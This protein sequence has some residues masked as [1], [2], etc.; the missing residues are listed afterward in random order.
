MAKNNTYKIISL[1]F[2]CFPRRILTNWG[3]KP[4]KQEGE[5][6]LPFDL[7]VTP[8]KS[9]CEILNNNF[10][11]YFKNL[12][13]NKTDSI[14]Y[15]SKY[16][17]YYYHDFDCDEKSKLINRFA[18]RIDNFKKVIN[19]DRFT[20]FIHCVSEETTTKEINDLYITLSNLCIIENFKLIILNV[21]NK[22]L[23]LPNYI[24]VINIQH[25]YKNFHAQWW[26]RTFRKSDEGIE[27]ETK[28][29]ENIKS[30]ISQRHDIQLYPEKDYTDDRKEIFV[31][32]ADIPRYMN[33]QLFTKKDN[34]ILNI[35]KK[36]YN[37]IVSDEPDFLF[38]SSFGNNFEKY[39]NCT[40]IFINWEPIIPNYNQCDYSLSYNDI[41]FG[42]RNLRWPNFY[43][44]LETNVLDKSGIDL[45]FAKRKFCNFI[46]I[47]ASGGEGAKLRNEFCINLSK[48]RKVDCPGKVLNNMNPNVI[49]PR[50]GDYT[51]GKLNFMK[52]YK[53]SII[54]ENTLL[55]GYTTEKIV[56]AFLANTIPIY[57]G[58]PDVIKEF[59]PR[60]FINCNDY[61]NL[62][63]VIEKVIELDND[64]KKYMEMLLQPCMQ[65][66][67][68]FNKLQLLEDYL[69]HI[70]EKGN[71]PYNKNPLFPIIN[72]YGY[73]GE[74]DDFFN[75][76]EYTRFLK[77]EY[78]R[79]KLLKALTF[80]SKRKHYKEKYNTLKKQLKELN[81]RR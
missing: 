18:N 50:E 16:E 32:F 53:F 58:N 76:P 56:H 51:K 26:P 69:I 33:S 23:S 30:I 77:F 9:I 35:L 59:N 74:I 45:S 60:A 2:N 13:F 8:T 6:T 20:Y 44:V 43:P 78:H 66:D 71:K 57:W 5:L 36:H 17:I 75:R 48:Y 14:W 73:V 19:D 27:F 49:S 81:P 79:A 7:C 70:I 11:D 40:K 22:Q 68:T 12:E 52:N 80:G 28:V 72:Q 25:P 4:S 39:H 31:N 61:K 54:F 10:A 1:G 62:D 38:Y 65:P 3:L 29:I 67:Y 37:V 55:N 21:F 47:N 63:E 24:E 41:K 42:D 64:D 15:N 46:H 34:F